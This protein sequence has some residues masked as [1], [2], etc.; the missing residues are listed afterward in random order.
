MSCTSACAIPA[1]PRLRNLLTPSPAGGG[2]AGEREAFSPEL[3]LPCCGD[4]LPGAPGSALLFLK[5]P[6]RVT[7]RRPPRFR[8]NPEAAGLNRAAKE[9]ASLRQLSPAFGFPAQGHH[10]R[11]HQRGECPV[12]AE[13][14]GRNSAAYSAGWYT[15]QCPSVIAPYVGWPSMYGGEALVA[16]DR[17]G[18]LCHSHGHDPG[19]NKTHTA[20]VCLGRVRRHAVSLYSPIQLGPFNLHTPVP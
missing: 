4:W 16:I 19:A 20:P 17:N 3:P 15:A 6:R 5:R 14:V 1:S 13:V 8:R 10:P 7:R 12:L 2:G 18:G 11:L 9:L